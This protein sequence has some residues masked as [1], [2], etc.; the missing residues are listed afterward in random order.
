MSFGK[1]EPY[2][3]PPHEVI[4]TTIKYNASITFDSIANNIDRCAEETPETVKTTLKT[5]IDFVLDLEARE[6]TALGLQPDPAASWKP[7]HCFYPDWQETQG[8]GAASRAQ[9]SVR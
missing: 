3:R 1:S 9:L 4:F 6:A 8:G 7:S 2:L 5:A